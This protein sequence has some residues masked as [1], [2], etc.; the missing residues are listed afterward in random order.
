MSA[1]LRP[2]ADKAPD[3]SEG[4]ARVAAERREHA[5]SLISAHGHLL[6]TIDIK[7]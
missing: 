2:A 3:L 6:V 1:L 4:E 5:L 7:Q